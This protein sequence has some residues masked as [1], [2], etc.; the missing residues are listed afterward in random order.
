MELKA[1]HD[2]HMGMTETDEVDDTTIPQRN[3]EIFSCSRTPI[4][5]GAR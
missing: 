2:A 3:R 1:V 4:S 5:N